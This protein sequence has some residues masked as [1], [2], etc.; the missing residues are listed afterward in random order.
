MLIAWKKEQGSDGTK[1]CHRNSAIHRVRWVLNAD[2]GSDPTCVPLAKHTGILK[3]PATH[4]RQADAHYLP[5]PFQ[6]SV[7]YT[8]P[9]VRWC[10]LGYWGYMCLRI[11]RHLTRRLSDNHGL[12]GNLCHWVCERENNLQFII[13]LHLINIKFL[14]IFVCYH[15]ISSALE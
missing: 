2:G 3:G 4:R 6:P 15:H 9:W 1:G 10:S 13:N 5:E 8:R 14:P 7:L 12:F 11:Q